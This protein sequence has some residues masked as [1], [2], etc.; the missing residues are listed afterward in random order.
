M[1]A[2]LAD[3]LNALDWLGVLKGAKGKQCRPVIKELLLKA[4]VLEIFHMDD[5]PDH[6]AV[7]TETSMKAFWLKVFENMKDRGGPE[8]DHTGSGYL[9]FLLWVEA[10][11]DAED[12]DVGMTAVAERDCAVQGAASAKDLV[13]FC[14]SMLLA[15]W[16]TREDIKGMG[17][18]APPQSSQAAKA[19]IKSKAAT[20]DTAMAQSKKEGDL[21]PLEIHISRMLGQW[22]MSEDK[23]AIKASFVFNK[24]WM[25]VKRANNNDADAI[26]GYVAEYFSLY[27]G[28]GLP[29]EHDG[30]IQS[31]ISA[32]RMSAALS[33]KVESWAAGKKKEE[34]CVSLEVLA[35]QICRRS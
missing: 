30:Q 7:L 2:A 13:R 29:V 24:W 35:Q 16:V 15:R 11:V 17:Y 1:S 14:V 32:K 33:G 28:R 19:A 9:S 18:G 6:G 21:G 25:G 26:L 31:A 3:E 20:W 8:D 27:A 4:H 34:E 12:E 5:V 23:F 10:R 22:A